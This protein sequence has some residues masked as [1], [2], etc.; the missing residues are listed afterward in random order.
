MENSETIYEDKEMTCPSLRSS[1]N[2]NHLRGRDDER[3][4]WEVPRIASYEVC[5]RT[6]PCAER[7]F[8][9]DSV[10][11]VRN[12]FCGGMRNY[13]KPQFSEPVND[14]TYRIGRKIEFWTTEHL[15]VLMQYL[16]M[17]KRD[18]SMAVDGKHDFHRRGIFY[19]APQRGDKDI[20]V[21]NSV[22][23]HRLSFGA[24]QRDFSL[25]VRFR[26]GETAFLGVSTERA[27]CF[28][29]SVGIDFFPK[30]FNDS[31]L[32]SERKSASLYGTPRKNGK[33]FLRADSKTGV[34]GIESFCYAVIK[35]NVHCCHHLPPLTCAV[36]NLT[37]HIIKY[38]CNKVKL[39]FAGCSCRSSAKE[40]RYA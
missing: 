6:S 17:D 36:S 28:L 20:R 8:I 25:N 14:G 37:I 9:K 35:H 21:D 40:I 1:R 11:L 24:A 39:I 33:R 15:F 2:L 5:L 10:V 12:D 29:E 18:D 34:N 22:Q 16:V 23:F 32:H 19:A 38:Q 13:R 27:E 4:I 30:A 31:P 3:L 7:D 26:Y